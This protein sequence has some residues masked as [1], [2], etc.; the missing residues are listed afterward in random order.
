MKH[1]IHIG[2]QKAGS[3]FLYGLLAQVPQVA[4]AEKQELN[5]FVRPG[6][7]SY[8]GYLDCFPEKRP[9]LFDN[10]PI[11]FREGRKAAEAIA[12]IV[13]EKEFTLSLF[14]RDPVEAMISLHQM[15]LNQG[16]FRRHHFPGDP[17]NLMAFIEANPDYVGVCRYMELL[18]GQWLP[19]LPAESFAIRIFEEFTARPVDT[20][21]EI[22]AHIGIDETGSVRSANV[23]KNMQPS[24]GLANWMVET[25]SRYPL[26]RA[27]TRRSMAVP[28]L[29]RVAT[30]ALFRKRRRSP[31]EQARIA[32]TKRKLAEIFRPDV[33][34]L[35]AF[36]GRDS[37]P[38][39]NFFGGRGRPE[40]GLAAGAR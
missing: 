27:A 6:D 8:A 38:W 25:A 30:T 39:S 20:V 1:W 13:G 16:F 17:R 5:F 2:T 33:M 40:D 10:S 37:L 19:S 26:L 36:L 14:L 9:V 23:W 22:A 4:L 3:S 15:R 7:Q 31:A 28:A 12:T 35:C 24:S 34:R 29:R 32:E 18:E 21:R 11:Y